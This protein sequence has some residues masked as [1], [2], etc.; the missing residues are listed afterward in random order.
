MPCKPTTDETRHL[1]RTIADLASRVP[2]SVWLLLP[3][4]VLQATPWLA[5]YAQFDRTAVGAGQFWRL[6]T[7]HLAHCN[8]EHLFWDAAMFVLLGT[9]CERRDRVAWLACCA[10]SSLTIAW[11]ILTFQPGIELYRGLSGIDTG[12]FVLLAIGVAAGR[13]AVRDWKSLAVIGG[14]LI[15]LVAKTAYEAVTGATL[16]VDSSTAGFVAVPLAHL[17]G[18]LTGGLIGLVRLLCESKTG[19]VEPRPVSSR[20]LISV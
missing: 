14:L 10:V 3:V 15:G 19:R 8:W 7:C 12:L 9:I 18:A 13:W 1:T 6:I 5:Q 4:L 16:F 2:Y 17:V 11:A 20:S